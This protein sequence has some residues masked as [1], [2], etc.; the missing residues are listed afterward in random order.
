MGVAHETRVSPLEVP[1]ALYHYQQW[2][3]VAKKVLNWYFYVTGDARILKCVIVVSYK[4]KISSSYGWRQIRKLKVVK[5]IKVAKNLQK[6][7]EVWFLCN[8]NKL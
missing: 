5:L 2:V 1:Y 7:S 4:I 6:N 3:A 8:L